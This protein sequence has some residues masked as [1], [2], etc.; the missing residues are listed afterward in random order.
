VHL[1]HDLIAPMGTPV[2]AVSD[3]YVV[4]VDREDRYDGGLGDRQGVALAIVTAQ[5]ERFF[6]AHLADIAPQ[7]QP[8]SPVVTGQVLGWV[9][10][11]GDAQRSVPHLHLEWRPDGR[12]HADPE[13]L[14]TGLCQ[15]PLG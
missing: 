4:R 1:G 9:G 6:Y 10:R 7:L 5:G 12:V 14:V 8:G 15:T 13:S 2:L 3:A 11:T